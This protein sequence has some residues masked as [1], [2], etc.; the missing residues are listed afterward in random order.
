MAS[1]ENKNQIIISNTGGLIRRMDHQLELMNRV[2]GKIAERKTEIIASGNSFIGM[3][4][5]AE[6]EWEI[7]PGVRIA[8]C[9]CPPGDFLMNPANYSQG[10]IHVTLTKGF[11]MAKTQVT[12]AQWQAVMGSNPSHFKGDNL[13]V[14]QVSW[15][16]TQNFLTK[17]N[18]LIG[19]DDGGSM[20]LPT[21]AQWEYASRTE[22]TGA[23]SGGI[24]DEVAWYEDNS[25]E[26][27]HPV[28]TKKPNAWGLHD[29]HGNVYEWCEDWYDNK[30][31]GGV[32]PRGATSGYDRVAKGGCWSS[33]AGN[34]G[35]ASRL[36]A[37]PS[38]WCNI[39]GFRVA[40]SLVHQ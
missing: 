26:K 9:W 7:A 13:P 30:L 4:A 5:G 39:G 28:G 19:S 16:A 25:G 36:S 31:P 6:R 21:E 32:D 22:E 2:L 8:F 15:G 17:V 23:F 35:A 40:R 37:P 20:V 18:A 24:I 27:T 34:C 10:Q 12:Q 29:M 11:W 33:T 14:E 3:M 1:E 38:G